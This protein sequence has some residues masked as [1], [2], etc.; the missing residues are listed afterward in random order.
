MANQ[1]NNVFIFPQVVGTNKA[2]KDSSARLVVRLAGIGAIRALAA[3]A[4]NSLA[5]CRRRCKDFLAISMKGG[6]DGPPCTA[7]AA[8][9]GS[10]PL[11]VR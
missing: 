8:G 2:E 11:N 9:R 5:Y 7:F 6:G 4:R 10:P 3:R 1:I